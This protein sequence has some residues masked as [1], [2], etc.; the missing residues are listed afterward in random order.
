MIR[1]ST[2]LV[3]PRNNVGLFTRSRIPRR[4]RKFFGVTVK[5]FRLERRY[6]E[7]FSPEVIPGTGISSEERVHTRHTHTYI[8][9]HTVLGFNNESWIVGV[10]THHLSFHCPFLP[11]HFPSS[12]IV[13]CKFA[14]EVTRNRLFLDDMEKVFFFFSN[15]AMFFFGFHCERPNEFAPLDFFIFSL[16]LRINSLNVCLIEF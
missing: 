9:T 15:H 16:D 11:F 8:H 6:R 13:L 10:K 14:D 3:F 7:T 4:W 5:Y 2:S 12:I 1:E